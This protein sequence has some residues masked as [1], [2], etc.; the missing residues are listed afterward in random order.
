MTVQAGVVASLG[1][2]EHDVSMRFAGAE[3]HGYKQ[4]AAE[5]SRWG[6]NVGVSVN[7][8]VTAETALHGSAEAVIRNA[9]T[10]VDAQLGVKMAF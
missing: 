3:A 6:Y 9:S 7:L 8:P 1:D 2:R 5:R 4:H 10:S